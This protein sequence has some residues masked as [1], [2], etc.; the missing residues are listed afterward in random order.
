MKRYH[1]A[2]PGIYVDNRTGNLYER[3]AIDGR[4]TWRKLRSRT[5]KY[6]K[7]ELAARRTDQGR[8]AYG[9]ARDPYEGKQKTVK[10]VCDQYLAAGCAGKSELNV[11]KEEN[12]IEKLL[13]FWGDRTVEKIR[14]RDCLDYLQRRQSKRSATDRELA[15]LSGVFRWAVQNGKLDGNPIAQ[16]PRFRSA[17]V[18]HCRDVMPVDADELHALAATLFE[19]PK[20]APLGWQLLLEAFTGCRTN[21][22]LQLRWDAGAHQPGHI[23]GQWL[24]LARS[25]GGVN[26]FALIH[27]ALRSLLSALKR[28]REDYNP[29]SPWFVP[30]FNR[31]GRQPVDTSSLVHKLKDIAGPICGAHRTSHGLRAYYVTVRRSQGIS[32][33]QIAAEI[34]DR[35]GAEIIA[36]T[37]G[38]I[39]PNW[40]GRAGLT[41]LPKGLPAWSVFQTKGMPSGMPIKKRGKRKTRAKP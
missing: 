5:L 30:S 2:A 28:W 17:K 8:A 31:E 26:P 22:V 13:P 32:D 3:P 39:P 25:K 9:L 19:Q 23:D 33:A 35:S 4:R 14:G 16:R 36:S 24:W 27:P 11:Y 6:A 40:Q 41:W 12:R 34:G 38:Q 37:Y 18:R 21:E 10:E 20:S 7:E 29:K 1:R 15:T